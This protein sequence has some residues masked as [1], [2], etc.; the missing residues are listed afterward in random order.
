M[1]KAQ[2]QMGETIV[3]IFILMILIMFGLVILYQFQ[4]GSARVTKQQFGSFKTIELTQ[5]VTN[6]P[7]LQCSFI[8]VTDVNCM[9]EVKA[10]ALSN[11]LQ[12]PEDPAFFYYREN[13]GTSKIEIDAIYPSVKK[14]VI[15]DNSKGYRNAEPTFIPIT[16]YDP[17]QK[18]FSFAL[19]QATRYYA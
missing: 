7:E 10:A 15:Y 5:I 8:E 14:I 19:L 12:N 1:K 2:V 4:A 3:V 17:A 9:D 18:V 16:L 11:L 13:L 6:M